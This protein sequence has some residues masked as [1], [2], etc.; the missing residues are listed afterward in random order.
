MGGAGSVDEAPGRATDDFAPAGGNNRGGGNRGGVKQ[1]RCRDE[2]SMASGCSSSSSRTYSD[3]GGSLSSSDDEDG[4]F[5]LDGVG[6]GDAA[7][8]SLSGNSSEWT[9]LLGPDLLR[10]PCGEGQGELFAGSADDSNAATE[11]MISALRNAV[12]ASTGGG[13]RENAGPCQTSPNPWQGRSDINLGGVG[14]GGGGVGDPG[15]DG[16]GDGDGGGGGGGGAGGVD[17]GG[18]TFDTIGSS[19]KE[20][21]KALGA[22]VQDTALLE[23]AVEGVEGGIAENI[24]RLGGGFFAKVS[25]NLTID[26]EGRFNSR[27]TT[28][29]TPRRQ[30]QHFFFPG[31]FLLAELLN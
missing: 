19:K 26:H 5:G 18:G 9:P 6:T 31:C 7:P 22:L 17:G 1:T 16:S 14:G 20:E 15:G 3:Y 29:Y 21:L 4:I 23:G 8:F 10:H 27:Y 2:T 13:F 28:Q 25:A 11:G 12:D 24:K 30:G